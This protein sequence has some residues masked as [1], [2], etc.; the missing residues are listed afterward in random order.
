MHGLEKT[1][2]V[3]NPPPPRKF[4]LAEPDMLKDAIWNFNND[5]DDITAQPE[6]PEWL[7]LIPEISDITETT[8]RLGVWPDEGEWSIERFDPIA[9]DLTGNLFDK[10]QGASWTR[11]PETLEEKDWY[12]VLGPNQNWIE[13]ILF[14]DRLPDRF[15]I[16][17]PPT[18]IMPIYLNRLWSYHWPLLTDDE[19]PTPWLLTH[20]YPSYLDWPPIWHWNLGIRMLSSLAEYLASQ[21]R[22]FMGPE[23]GAWNPDKSQKTDKDADSPFVTTSDGDRL[24]WNPDGPSE[25]LVQMDWHRFPG[26]IPFI[27]GADTF[28]LRWFTEHV[29]G[30]GFKTVAIDAVNSIAHENFRGIP[31]AI[32]T[33]LSAGAKHV[34][35]YGPWPLHPPSKYV[36]TK[37]VSYIPSALHMDMT[38]IPK[39]YWRRRTDSKTGEELK[40]KRLPSYR[41]T[42]LPAATHLDHVEICN[43]GAC[44]AGKTKEID[45]RSIWKWGHLL[46]AGSKWVERVSKRKQPEPPKTNDC[47]RLW[48]QGPS[49]TVFRKCLHYPSEAKWE[50]IEGL[51]ETIEFSETRMYVGFVEESRLDSERIRWT[52]FEDI[53]AWAD[54]FPHLEE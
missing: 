8:S 18:A 27:P 28:Q 11:D 35:V 5:R 2:P 4:P 31:E 9:W 16:Q 32:A 51:L 1:C 26:I 25:S 20:G 43:C 3:Y 17:T 12:F 33:L 7:L 29:V 50:S 49:Y 40:W 19:A 36:P 37:N 6:E 23:P 42:S 39:R 48:Y 53:H 14:V 13:H 24:I 21:T 15:A 41:K 47:M 38:D 30:M 46:N 44:R 52:W 54:G 10:V 45:P 34:F 22:G